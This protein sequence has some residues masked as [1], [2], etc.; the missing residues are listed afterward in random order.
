M[1]NNRGGVDVA[2]NV[3]STVDSKHHLI[4]EYNVITNPSDQG[5][6]S[7]MTKK[8]KEEGYEDFTSLADKGFYNGEDLS[9][10]KDLNIKAIVARQ[11]PSNPKDQPPM[12]HTDK[13]HY[14]KSTNSYTCPIGQ[15]L[16]SHSK[17]NAKRRNYYNKEACKN[18]LHKNDCIKGKAS[19]RTITRGQHAEVLEES[20]KIYEENKEL[21]KQRQQLVEHPFGTIKRTMH[22]GYFLLRTCEKVSYEAALLC[23][24]YNLKRVYNAMGFD[25][26]MAKLNAFTLSISCFQKFFVQKYCLSQFVEVNRG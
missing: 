22:G 13:F 16:Q 24:G 4:L 7:V 20:D 10:M 12:F 17:K 3:I 23:L 2:Y 11:K 21:Y 9:K 26:I 6:L 15:N 25:K 5:Q 19:Y 8:L 18:C 1:G 14:D